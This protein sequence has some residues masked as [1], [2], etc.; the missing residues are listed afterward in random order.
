LVTIWSDCSVYYFDVGL[1]PISRG[2]FLIKH[3][4]ASGPGVSN[5][6]LTNLRL[7]YFRRLYILKLYS[8]KVF[9]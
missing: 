7:P 8:V 3:V 1:Q 6:L 9:I 4:Y 5:W 2:T